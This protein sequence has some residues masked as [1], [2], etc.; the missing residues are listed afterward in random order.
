LPGT[1]DYAWG[2]HLDGSIYTINSSF[3]SF[4]GVRPVIELPKSVIDKK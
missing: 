3:S 2:V 4:Y 1:T